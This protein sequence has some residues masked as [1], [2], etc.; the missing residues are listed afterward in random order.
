[1]RL[2]PCLMIAAAAWWGSISALTHP[3][4]AHG[5]EPGYRKDQIHAVQAWAR[6]SPVKGRPAAVFFTLHNESAIAD[7]LIGVRTPIAARAEIHAHS[8]LNGVMKMAALQRVPVAPDDLVL[9]EPGNY[10]VMLF[11]LA[12]VPKPGSHFP[13][14]LTFARGKPQTIEVLSKGLVDGPPKS[15]MEHMHH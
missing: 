8:S 11:D 10:H 15:A 12:S 13:L 1:M 2:K 3:A 7:A 9:F 5:S 14:T 4:Q 6:I